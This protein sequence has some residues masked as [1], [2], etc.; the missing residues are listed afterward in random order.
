MTRFRL[1][2]KKKLLFVLFAIFVSGQNLVAIKFDDEKKNKEFNNS[3]KKDFKNGRNKKKNKSVKDSLSL[4]GLDF[5]EVTS[6][7]SSKKFIDELLIRDHQSSI[8]KLLID[9]LYVA[10]EVERRNNR[11]KFLKNIQK[12]HEKEIY[13]LKKDHEDKINILKKKHKYETEFLQKDHKYTMG[14]IQADQAG[15][16]ILGIVVI[17]FII[18]CLYPKLCKE[19]IK[20]RKKATVL[21]NGF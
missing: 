17:G 18:A 5:E 19:K 21:K 1:L 9:L 11:I 12:N 16:I 10:G 8:F 2:S 20:K 6:K 7:I 14:R 3:L 15:G 13:D 4:K